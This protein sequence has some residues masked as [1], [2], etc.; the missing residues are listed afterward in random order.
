VRFQRALLLAKLGQWG[1]AAE[2]LGQV[3]QK[4]GRGLTPHFLHALCTLAAKQPDAYRRACAGLRDRLAKAR[5]E[6]VND[7]V[8][9]C[10]LGPDALPN[11]EACLAALTKIVAAK[12]SGYQYLNT[13]GALLYRAGRA[14]EAARRLHEAMQ[15][16]GA[17]GN[18]W[19]WLFLA[20]AQHR[21]GRATEARQT[22]ERAVAWIEKAEQGQIED[23]FCP[24]PLAWQSALE[25]RLLRQEVETHLGLSAAGPTTH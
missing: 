7:I 2:E 3:G 10:V 24:M 17:G 20:L 21:L 6:E 4:E 25:L 16:H 9:A 12:P 13:L 5:T 19:D 18:A 14:E 1:E 15:A 22:L 8:W 11:Y 23:R